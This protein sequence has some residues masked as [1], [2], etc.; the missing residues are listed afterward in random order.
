M[1]YVPC[2]GPV[3]AAIVLAGATG[4]IGVDTVALT[5]SFAVGAALPLLFFALAGRRV[6]ER[7]SAFRNR[8]RQIR[9]AQ[10]FSV[11]YG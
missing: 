3:L 8:Q 6:A 5:L 2:A 1:L 4:A 7:L 11:T 9:V 10:A